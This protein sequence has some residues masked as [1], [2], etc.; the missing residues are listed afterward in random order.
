MAPRG[1]SW[2]LARRSPRGL[3]MNGL[4]SELMEDLERWGELMRDLPGLIRFATIASVVVSV[5]IV[6][7]LVAVAVQ[8]GRVVDAIRDSRGRIPAG[9]PSY[10]GP[11]QHPGQAPVY[12]SWGPRQQG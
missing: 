4:V 8:L 1:D 12:G 2:E 6:G 5:A 7:S 3:V 11:S 9:G 10:P